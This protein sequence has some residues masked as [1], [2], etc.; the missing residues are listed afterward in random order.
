MPSTASSVAKIQNIYHLPPHIA[1]RLTVTE[2]LQ[3][4]FHS[5][6]PQNLFQNCVARYHK[7]YLV[8][9]NYPMLK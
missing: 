6:G 2:L 3:D 7:N 5:P 4:G 1:C 9:T 8:P